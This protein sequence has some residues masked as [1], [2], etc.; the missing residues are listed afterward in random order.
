MGTLIHYSFN[1]TNIGNRQPQQ[2]QKQSWVGV[3]G[4]ADADGSVDWWQK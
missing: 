1:V 2:Q 4:D 3:D